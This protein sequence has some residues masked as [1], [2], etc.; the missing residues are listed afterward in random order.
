MERGRRMRDRRKGCVRTGVAACALLVPEPASA[1]PD[2]ALAVLAAPDVVGWAGA[3]VVLILSAAAVFAILTSRRLDGSSLFNRL[4]VVVA[5][6]SGFFSAVSSAIGFQLITGQETEDFFRNSLL[7]PAFGVFVFFL[8]VAIWVGGAELVRERDW[9]RGLGRGFIADMAFFLERC[10][11]LFI[12]IPILA[13]ILLFVSTWT[14]VVGIAGVDAVRHTYN[15]EIDRLQAECA[16]VT[17]YRQK[18]FLFREDLRLSVRDV[19]RV[20]ESERASGSQSGAAGR[21]AVTDYFIG[22]ADWL[23]GLESSVDAIIGGDDPTGV[24][25]YTPDICSS[26]ID[27]LRRALAENGFANYDLW[28]REFE[29]RFDDFAIIVNRWRQDRRIE[30][31]L[32]QQIANFDR[33]NPKPVALADGRLSVGQAQAIED[34]A[35]SVTDALKSLLRKQRLAKPPVPLASYVELNPERGLDIIAAIFRAEAPPPAEARVPRTAQQ[36]A[37]EVIPGLSRITP[38]DAVLKNAKIF[39][40]VWAL[41]LAWDYAAYVLMLAY[42]FFPS[43]ERASGRKDERR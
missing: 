38:R 3:S 24:S 35:A 31:L 26:T 28:A 14:T 33:A 32:D 6:S 17:A 21:G 30:R 29:T 34:Y 39:S 4:F 9:F 42:L 13:V 23:S 7:P 12:V 43:A 22:V 16:G 40:D 19:R 8:A 5:T 25:P 10:I 41:G 27:G 2:S 18:D 37:A 15:F 36:V 20:A 1:Q 11:K